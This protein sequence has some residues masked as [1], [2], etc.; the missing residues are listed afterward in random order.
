MKNYDH[1]HNSVK[2]CMWFGLQDVAAMVVPSAFWL[3]DSD[4]VVSSLVEA[5]LKELHWYRTVAH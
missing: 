5:N 4:L 1:A 2:L 3:I